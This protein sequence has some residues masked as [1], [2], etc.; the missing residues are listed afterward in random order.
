MV[1][2]LWWTEADRAL[3]STVRVARTGPAGTAAVGHTDTAPGQWER[4]PGQAQPAPLLTDT[5]TQP[6]VSGRDGPD[7]PSRHRC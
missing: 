6:P 3:R 1:V 5:Q 7:R 2:W 4:W